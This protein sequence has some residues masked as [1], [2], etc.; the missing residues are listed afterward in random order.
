MLLILLHPK[1]TGTLRLKS[2]NPF[3]HPILDPKYF[4]VKRDIDIL[5]DGKYEMFLT[6]VLPA[7][8]Q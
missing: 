8:S 1:S 3:E 6:T 4:K 2:Q 7:T 5:I